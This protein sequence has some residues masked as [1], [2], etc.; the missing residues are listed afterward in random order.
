MEEAIVGRKKSSRL[1]G[2]EAVR[3]EARLLELKQAE[4]ER[5]LARTKRAE[6]RQQREAS[7]REQREAAR[8]QR[9]LEREQKEAQAALESE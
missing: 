9:R 2:K 8:E 3:E 6:A 7:T 1:A 4:E 5:E